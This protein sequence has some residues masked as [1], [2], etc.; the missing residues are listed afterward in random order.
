MGHQRP[1]PAG[2]RAAAHVGWANRRGRGAG[3]YVPNKPPDGLTAPPGAAQRAPG[4][5]FWGLSG[6][7]GRARGGP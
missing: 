2:K 1:P 4:D 6:R 5:A 7:L 3:G